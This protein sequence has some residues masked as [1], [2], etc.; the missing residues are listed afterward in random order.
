MIVGYKQQ[1]ISQIIN[2][3]AVRYQK[4]SDGIS[5]S[6]FLAIVAMTGLNLTAFSKLLPVSKRTL[7]KIKDKELI[8]A[9]VSDRILQIAALYEYGIEVLGSKVAFQ[10]WLDTR[11]MALADK[12]PFEL[13]DT[14]SGLSIVEDLLG[15]IEHGIYS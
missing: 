9:P 5:K 7:E 3:P 11:L 1:D 14:G 10:A 12:K 4:A 13:M 15:R 6:D 2:D 8:S